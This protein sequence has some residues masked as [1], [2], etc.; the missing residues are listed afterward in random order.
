MH[1]FYVER[2]SAAL[3]VDYSCA[4]RLTGAI[5][6]LTAMSQSARAVIGS[7]HF[8]VQDEHVPIPEAAAMRIERTMDGLSTL[9]LA[10]DGTLCGAIGN[11]DPLRAGAVRALQD[12]RAL[13]FRRLVMLT[14]DNEHAAARI[15]REA[16]ITE[17]CADLLPARKHEIVE[18]LQ[19]EGARVVMVGDGANDSP[20]LSVANVGVAMGSGTAIAKEVADITLSEGDLFSLVV[21]CRLSQRLDSRMS[22]RSTGSS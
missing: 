7:E 3:M 15:A 22:P 4:L 6:V 8:V 21:L 19:A 5:A 17:F 14:G 1:T 10:V 20:A 13:G 18:Q 9:Y 2:T 16:V 12:L 11:E